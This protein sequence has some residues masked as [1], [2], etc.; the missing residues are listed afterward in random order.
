MTVLSSSLY[1]FNSVNRL[2]RNTIKSSQF[3]VHT[4]ENLVLPPFTGYGTTRSSRIN[5]EC[6]NTLY[7]ARQTTLSHDSNHINS[8]T[9]FTFIRSM[10]LLSVFHIL[11]RVLDSEGGIKR[12]ESRVNLVGKQ[13]N[14]WRRLSSEPHRILRWSFLMDKCASSDTLSW[15][16]VSKTASLHPFSW[17]SERW[18]GDY[19]PQCVGT[20]TDTDHRGTLIHRLT[21]MPEWL[22]EVSAGWQNMVLHINEGS[23]GSVNGE[24]SCNKE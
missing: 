18:Q 17:V 1:C 24:A 3:W 20:I 23:L 22:S 15:K 14:T 19:N 8:S 9:F 11:V 4:S 6:I 13:S 5:V 7:P 2:W 21:H 16:P 12:L 10:N